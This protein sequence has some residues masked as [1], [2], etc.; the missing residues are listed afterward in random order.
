M[1]RTTILAVSPA[2][3]SNVRSGRVLIRSIAMQ[4]TKILIIDAENAKSAAKIAASSC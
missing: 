1:P 2:G 3:M 4:K